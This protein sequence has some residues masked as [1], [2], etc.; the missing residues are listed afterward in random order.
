MEKR[1]LEKL[2][3]LHAWTLDE[4]AA[5]GEEIKPCAKCGQHRLLPYYRSLCESCWG[6]PRLRQAGLWEVN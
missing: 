2:S 5:A 3:A 4:L 6:G 1:G